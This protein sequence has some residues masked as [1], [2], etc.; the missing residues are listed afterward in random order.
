MRQEI[1]SN[2]VKIYNRAIVMKYRIAAVCPDNIAEDVR[3]HE[4][5]EVFRRTGNGRLQHGCGVA[6][7]PGDT[8]LFADSWEDG[9]RQFRA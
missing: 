5:T 8:E 2:Y 1:F 9:S 7:A 6:T 3:Q 4:T